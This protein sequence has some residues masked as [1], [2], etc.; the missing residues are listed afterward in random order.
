MS[1]SLSSERGAGL[2]EYGLVAML[3]GILA[4]GAV[5]AFGTEVEG[6]YDEASTAIA[7]AGDSEADTT[8]EEP[9]EEE[10][11]EGEDQEGEENQGDEENEGG[12]PGENPACQ[13]SGNKPPWCP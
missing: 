6:M 4:L 10:G 3:I 13:Q 7:N 1:R 9:S 12:P 8:E 5:R 2:V 11:T